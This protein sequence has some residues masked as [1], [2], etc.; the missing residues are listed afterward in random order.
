MARPASWTRSAAW[1]TPCA[2]VATTMVMRRSATRPRRWRSIAIIRRAAT[3]RWATA[4]MTRG[5][6]GTGERSGLG[7]TS[8]VKAA[9][10]LGGRSGDAPREVVQA[11]RNARSGRSGR[12]RIRGESSGSGSADRVEGST[13]RAEHGVMGQENPR[14]VDRLGGL[15][16]VATGEELG[17]VGKICQVLAVEAHRGTRVHRARAGRRADVGGRSPG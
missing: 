14:W 11:A 9:T 17:G 10:S 2:R 6:G 12:P 4:L 8:T 3:G 5:R 7:F 13:G 16:A 15:R 1:V